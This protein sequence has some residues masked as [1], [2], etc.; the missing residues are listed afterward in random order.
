M[1]RGGTAIG[2]PLAASN[3]QG[4]ATNDSA[5]AG[6]IGEYVS[7]TIVTGSSVALTTNTTANVASISLTA[8]DWD[9]TGVIDFTFGATTSYT[10]LQGGISI[11]SATIGAQD[12]FFDLENAAT[13]P[14]ATKDPAFV[15]PTIRISIAATT[16]V[17]LVA[18]ATFTVSTL[19]AYGTISARRAR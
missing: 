2:I 18:Q 4:T 1:I 8:G 7:S 9:V 10:N 17:Y 13:V 5:A 12:S 15:C 19:K 11:T 14:T 6:Y 3:I 16:T